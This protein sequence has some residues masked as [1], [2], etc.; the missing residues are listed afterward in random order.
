MNNFKTFF[1]KSKVTVSSD[2]F[3]N[4]LAETLDTPKYKISIEDSFLEPG[5][6][7][8]YKE[9]VSKYNLE[10]DIANDSQTIAHIYGTS[11]NL[12]DF[13]LD[14]YKLSYDDINLKY[15]KDRKSVV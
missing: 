7:S 9:G 12:I 11:D 13:L 6:L 15:P 10:F 14:I 1:K 5:T 3:T 4:I 2:N 8:I